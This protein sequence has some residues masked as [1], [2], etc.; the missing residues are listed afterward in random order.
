[1][2]R[3]RRLRS[4][5]VL[6]LVAALALSVVAV[7][8]SLAQTG[9]AMAT[10]TTTDAEAELLKLY[11]D[12]KLVSARSRAEELISTNDESIVAH[13]VL[14]VS[15]RESEGQLR[16]ALTELARSR[17]LMEARYGAQP[18]MGQAAQL[19]QEILVATQALAGEL[20]E[21]EFQLKILDFHD[22]LYEPDLLAERAWVQLRLGN[23]EAARATAKRAMAVRDPWQQSL[24]KNALC[25][26]EGEAQTRQPYYD[27]CLDALANARARSTAKNPP[28]GSE[29]NLAVHAYNAAQAAQASMHADDAE[30]LALEGTHTPSLTIANPWRILVRL[31]ADQGRMVEAVAAS[32]EMQRWRMRLPANLRIQDRAETDVAL[33]TLLLVVGDPASGLRLADRA[34]E[35]PDRRGLVSSKAE[36]AFGA[37]A[38]L[39]RALRRV[40]AERDA[41]RASAASSLADLKSAIAD[42]KGKWL[43]RPDD[44]RI[45]AILADEYRLVSTLRPYIHGGLEPVPSWLVGDLIEVLGAGVVA[46]TLDRVRE[47]ERDNVSLAPFLDAFDAEIALAQGKLTKALELAER[48]ANSLPKGEALLIARAAAI[49]AQAATLDGNHAKSLAL[50]ERAMQKDPGVIRRLGLAIPAK[51]VAPDGEPELIEALTRLAH[52]PRLNVVPAGQGAFSIELSKERLGIAVCLRSPTGALL[53]CTGVVTKKDQSSEERVSELVNEFHTQ[54]F[55]ARVGLNAVDIKSLDGANSLANQQQRT[56]LQDALDEIAKQH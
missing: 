30:K 2:R 53:G 45:A 9:G 10:F 8:S 26:I 44:A 46:V 49:G 31:Y 12:N 47:I 36:Q 40:Q 16:P 41:E 29:P 52:S 22:A 35:Q 13:F 56:Q 1:M 25:G 17:E 23:L 3:S 54:L 19:H 21:H 34:I 33:A 18:P 5:K 20:E 11:K 42:T 37:A 28:P 7:D 43:A 6:P 4:W 15:L 32:S 50:F 27:A 55:A 38:L 24:G 14:G 39:R 51:I 48:A